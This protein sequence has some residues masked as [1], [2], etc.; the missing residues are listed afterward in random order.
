M[1][2]LD[3]VLQALGLVDL[4]SETGLR[5][6]LVALFLL[7]EAAASEVRTRWR[8]LKEAEV[9]AEAARLIGSG[10]LDARHP[11]FSFCGDAGRDAIALAARMRAVEDRLLDWDHGA[12]SS[13]RDAW[14]VYVADRD[15]HLV[16]VEKPLWRTRSRS[17]GLGPFPARALRFHRLLPARLHG[18]DV[19]VIS[20]DRLF[21]GAGC[22]GALIPDLKLDLEKHADR[23]FTISGLQAP[24]YHAHLEQVLAWSMRF[25]SVAL[26]LPEL[27]IDR[28][29]RELIEAQLAGKPWLDAGDIGVAAGPGLVAAGS[30][31]ERGPDGRMRNRMVIYDADGLEVASYCKRLQFLLGE[32]T[33]GVA[34]GTTQPVLATRGGLITFGICRDVCDTAEVEGGQFYRSLDVDLVLVPS[35]GNEATIQGHAIAAAGLAP[36]GRRLFVVQQ[37]YGDP[38]PAPLG[39]VLP[40][41]RLSGEENAAF[42]LR[43]VTPMV[44]CPFA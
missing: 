19:E 3:G 22:T 32:R 39:Y 4:E 24:D 25:G 14:R 34:P 37:S 10:W 40:P 8:A 7:G 28:H 17:G 41:R 21:E 35:L 43:Q 18:C 11:E 16:P 6:T 38:A 20:L 1:K 31:H 30:W 13:S 23:T 29:A 9:S 5:E 42:G 15:M 12:R 27:A 26:V 36:L 33:E 44:H 2:N